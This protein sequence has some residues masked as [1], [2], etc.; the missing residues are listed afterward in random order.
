MQNVSWGLDRLAE[1]SKTSENQMRDL[2]RAVGWPPHAPEIKFVDI[3]TKSGEKSHPIFCPIDCYEKIVNNDTL[4]DRFRGPPEA[5]KEYWEG[6]RDS[7]LYKPFAAMIDEEKTIPGGIRADGAPTTKVDGLFT[8]NWASQMAE[9]PTIKK[10]SY[11]L[12]CGRVI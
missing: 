9:G 10:N 8:I 6:M 3:P 4:F 5:L 11:L 2:R 1:K 12:S 7:V